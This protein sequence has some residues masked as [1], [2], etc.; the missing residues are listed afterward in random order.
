ME[1]LFSGYNRG[2]QKAL[3]DLKN[4]FENGE[5]QYTKT[6]K[7]YKTMVMSV[8]KLLS[9]DSYIRDQFQQMGDLNGIV[10]Q[11]VSVK[12]KPDGTVFAQYER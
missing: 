9:E 3:I 4:L 11:Y 5:S 7:Q 1:H 6:K 10:N 2:Y 8:L 12:Q